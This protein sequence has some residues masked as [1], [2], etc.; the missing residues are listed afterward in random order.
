MV[1]Y[2]APGTALNDDEVDLVFRALADS[3]R[4]DI[5]RR[6]LTEESSI[7]D[8]AQR[9]K[10]SFAAVQ[11]H[12]GVLESA[13][14]VTKHRSGRE[15]RVRGRPEALQTAQKLLNTYE[16]IWQGRIHRLDALLAEE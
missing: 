5:V 7:S 8:L 14:L 16:K 6:T 15:R 1:A 12:I 11:K 13:G 9:Y 3:T 4:R 2:Q 10:M